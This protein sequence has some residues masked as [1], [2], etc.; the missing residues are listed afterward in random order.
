MYFDF[1]DHNQTD[2]EETREGYL[3]KEITHKPHIVELVTM[4]KKPYSQGMIFLI[5]TGKISSNMK[6]KLMTF[7]ATSLGDN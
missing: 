3:M 7:I 6:K 4:K 5:S 2:E 1:N